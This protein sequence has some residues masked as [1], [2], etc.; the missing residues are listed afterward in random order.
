MQIT[1]DESRLAVWAAKLSANTVRSET[2]CLLWTGYTQPNGYGW[3]NGKPKIAAHRASL[4]VSGVDVPADMDVCHR[5]DVRNCVEPAHLYVGS[6]RQNMADCTARKRHNKPR[7]QRHW[8]AK[9]TDNQV[10]EIRRR[11]GAGE[12]QI[13]VAAEFNVHHATVSRIARRVWRGEVA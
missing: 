4:V 9:L 10:R 6:R 1:I 8:C 12:M 3:I 5:C 7:G 2:G 13:A 11:C